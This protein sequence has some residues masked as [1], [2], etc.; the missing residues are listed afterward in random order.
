[1]NNNDLLVQTAREL[2]ARL[3]N[4][5]IDRASFKAQAVELSNENDQLRKQ[6]EDLKTKLSK[7][8]D[9]KTDS[10]TQTTE[11]E[12]KKDPQANK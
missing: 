2:A 11:P 4:A 12:T 7:E 1:M 10:Q 8:D 9:K 5:E 3:S 6:I